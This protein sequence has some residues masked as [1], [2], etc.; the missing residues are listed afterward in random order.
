[1]TPNNHCLYN[2]R[3]P[4]PE[5][6]T[7]YIGDVTP[8]A[9][10]YIGSLGLVFDNNHDERVTLESVP[11]GPAMSV[12]LLSLQAVQANQKVTLIAIGVHLLGG[13]LTFPKDRACSRLNE[14]TFSPSAPVDSVCLAQRR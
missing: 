12:N 9:V 10:E 1:M 11:F 2:L 6:A 8:P 7:V 3:P 4:S 5:N 13:R 14:I